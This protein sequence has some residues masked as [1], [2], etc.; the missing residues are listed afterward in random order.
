MSAPAA[1]PRRSYM[2]TAAFNGDFYTYTPAS[3]NVNTNTLTAGSLTANVTGATAANCPAGHILHETGKRLY[4]DVHSG[5]STLMVSVWDPVSTYTGYIDPNAP[6][7]TIYNSDKAYYMPQA[8]NPNGG[9]TDL[10]A[11]VYT[12][13]TVTANTGCYISSGQIRCASKVVVVDT[14]ATT[15]TIDPSLSQ[16][17]TLTTTQ[18]ANLVATNLA[19][20]AGSIVYLLITAGG[21]HTITPTTAGNM[22]TAAAFALTSG[23]TATMT[24]VS[25]GTTLWEIARSQHTISA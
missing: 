25:D 12:R 5:V 13:G 3:F 18:S 11:P 9:A 15:I 21:S 17:F 19:G 6:K 24:F 16:I 1:T 10:A 2:T 7:F 20:T 4:P 22:R 14:V 8:I 23:K